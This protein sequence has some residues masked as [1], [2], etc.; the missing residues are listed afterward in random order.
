MA[1][2][3][4]AALSKAV[5]STETYSCI[6]AMKEVVSDAD[7][8]AE[9]L[10][11]K[12]EKQEINQ[13]MS[14]E[15]IGREAW[16]KVNEGEIIRKTISVATDSVRRYA[17]VLNKSDVVNDDVENKGKPYSELTEEEKQ[18]IKEETGWS[19]EII[20]HIK[21]MDQY[22]I[23]KN[24]DLHEAEINGR[25][26]L[27]KDI[28]MDYVDPK[29]GMTNRERLSHKP[30]PLSPID[31]KTGEKIEL[32]HM[33]QEFDAPFAELCENS[34]H[35]DGNHSVLHDVNSES[36]RRDPEKKHEY[37]EQKDAHWN[38]RVTE[39]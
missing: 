19:D 37:Q 23:Y 31:S 26:C 9:N 38:N 8:I 5:E 28:D 30:H 1:I 18:N 3:V 2:P 39:V 14:P 20:D 12:S 25:K 17:D 27:I 35:G 6:E 32:H 16:K 4:V 33:G 15:D 10:W 22:E 13:P 34:E 29:T 36:W 21:D 7:K 11:P 24:A